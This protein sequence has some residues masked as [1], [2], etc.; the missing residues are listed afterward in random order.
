MQRPKDC[1]FVRDPNL[2]KYGQTAELSPAFKYILGHLRTRAGL[3]K[4]K[5]CR[6]SKMPLQGKSAEEVGIQEIWDLYQQFDLCKAGGLPPPATIQS[7]QPAAA[8]P[9]GLRANLGENNAQSEATHL[10]T[11]MGSATNNLTDAEAKVLDKARGQL[12]CVEIFHGTNAKHDALERLNGMAGRPIAVYIEVPTSRKSVNAHA[13]E[14]AGQ[15]IQKTSRADN[16]RVVCQLHTRYDLFA[17]TQ[18]KM[19]TVFPKFAVEC[20]QLQRSEKQ[21]KGRRSQFCFA[22]VPEAE[23]ISSSIQVGLA[24]SLEKT[25]LRCT[26]ACCKFRDGAPQNEQPADPFEEVHDLDKDVDLLR[27]MLADEQDEE[28]EESIAQDAQAEEIVATGCQGTD[29]VPAGQQSSKKYAV[30]MWPFAH[31]V[32][33]HTPVMQELLKPDKCACIVIVTSSAHPSVWLA[34]RKCFPHVFVV[35]ERTSTHQR[36]HAYDVGLT[37]TVSDAIASNDLTTK[38]KVSE[39]TFSDTTISGPQLDPDQQ[40]VGGW[41]ENKIQKMK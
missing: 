24:R 23:T 12:Q 21:A 7:T 11:L 34:A 6:V 18:E 22:A 8:E 19:R 13:I 30:D 27:Q 1:R 4:V 28:T 2:E 29:V 5:Q 15:C 9:L 39:H 14:F 20:V 37:L 33:F 3:K 26:D 17:G 41:R 32:A 36:A 38:R 25:M 31:P 40:T 35:Q 10:M 16:S